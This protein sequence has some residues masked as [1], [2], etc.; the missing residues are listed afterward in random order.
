[1]AFIPYKIKNNGRMKQ[2]K[3]QDFKLE[4]ELQSLVEENLKELFGITFLATEYSTGERHGGRMDTLGIDENNS[5]VILE[6]KKNKNQNIINQALFYLDWLVDHK[7]AFELLV[8]DTLNQKIEIDW[9][10][11][12]VLCIAE[13]FNKYDTYAVDQMKRPIELIQYR[14]FEDNIFALDILTAAEE[15]KGNNKSSINKNYSV[16]DHLTSGTDKTRELFDE[17]RDFTLELAD[18]VVESPR[19]FYIAYRVIRNFL[20]LEIHKGHL[21]LYLRLSLDEVDLEHEMIRDVSD[22]GHYG[23]GDVEVRV[24]SKD[25]IELAKKLIEKAY[26]NS[27]S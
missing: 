19:K 18:D 15:S 24:E 17:L 26:N 14:V 4:K 3:K 22:I 11:P 13:E 1:M 16:D 7:S 5:P 25:D 2:L 21:L 10:S 27:G 20:C 8:R 23:T 9:S 6:Y 12:R